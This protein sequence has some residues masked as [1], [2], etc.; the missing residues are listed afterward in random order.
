VLLWWW[1]WNAYGLSGL[2]PR[3]VRSS[4]G[5]GG[6]SR[7]L[8]VVEAE[9]DRVQAQAVDAAVE[10]ELHVVQRRLAHC[11]VVEVQVR[12]RG[13]EVVQEVLASAGFP[14]PCHTAE[15]RQ[16]VVGRRAV[17][18]ASAHTYQSAFALSRLRGFP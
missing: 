12:L 8:C 18:R 14:L 2:N 1:Y 13:Q 7:S 16:P 3:P 11:R 4:S 15:D 6:L 10:P 9:I 5:L 17:R